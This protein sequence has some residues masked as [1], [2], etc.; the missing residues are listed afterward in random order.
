MAQCPA[1]KERTGSL[2]VSDGRD[3]KILVHCFGG[4]GQREVIDALR[5]QGLWP[6]N[7]GEP[8]LMSEA[9]RERRRRQEAERTREKL[10]KDAFIENLW[11]RTHAEAKPAT[12]EIERWLEHRL[13]AKLASNLDI[14]RL[15]LR[16]SPRCPRGEGTAPAMVALMTDPVTGEACGIHRTY[17]LPDG[18]GKAPV[19]PVRQMLGS[20][21]VIRLSPDD[22]IEDCLGIAEGIETA[23]AVMAIGWRPMW[24]CGSLGGVTDFP[25]LAGVDCITIFSD[26]KP[27][28][29]EGARA[30][31]KRWAEAGRQ[32]HLRIPHGGVDWNEAIRN[33]ALQGGA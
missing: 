12:R 10:R 7:A 18:S 28:E 22:E 6:G 1:H 19:E 32:A 24:A 33:D 13:G 31:R 25:V 3:G 27:H 4:C 17:L 11:R 16:W 14:A 26:P 8:P 9:E 5:E 29:V 2:S 21:G 15:P 20:R 30:C 23:L